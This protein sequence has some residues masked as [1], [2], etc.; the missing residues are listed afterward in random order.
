MRGEVKP[1]AL[2]L[3]LPLP[4]E[5][6]DAVEWAGADV[7][8]LEF[9]PEIKDVMYPGARWFEVH[10]NDGLPR[11]TTLLTAD[12]EIA[13]LS[14]N[15]CLPDRYLMPI[16]PDSDVRSEPRQQA[17]IHPRQD[18]RRTVRAHNDCATT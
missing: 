11:P 14:T 9:V 16:D 3:V 2:C 13:T 1:G 10:A 17:T 8:V 6:C 4:P 12:G 5:W 15:V 18:G 7:T